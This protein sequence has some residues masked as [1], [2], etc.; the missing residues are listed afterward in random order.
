MPA[1]VRPRP[2]PLPQATWSGICWRA[3]CTLMISHRLRWPACLSRYGGLGRSDRKRIHLPPNPSQRHTGYFESHQAVL[4]GDYRLHDVRPVEPFD[5]GTCRIRAGHHRP[6]L[7]NVHTDSH[8]K[9]S[10]RSALTTASRA[11]GAA[12]LERKPK[13]ASELVGQQ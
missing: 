1:C 3:C 8:P 9:G 13:I 2:S 11:W 6:L 7:L 12:S 4:G 10:R 5:N